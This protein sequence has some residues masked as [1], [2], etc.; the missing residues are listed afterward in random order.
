MDSETM[1]RLPC[2]G[3]N[4]FVLH[5]VSFLEGERARNR[6]KDLKEK[7]SLRRRRMSVGTSGGTMVFLFLLVF[8]CS[9][10]LFLFGY[11]LLVSY[12]YSCAYMNDLL[13]SYVG[14]L[15][16]VLKNREKASTIGERSRRCV[17]SSGLPENRK[18][19]RCC[20]KRCPV[21]NTG[22]MIPRVLP[23]GTKAAPSK[24]SRPRD[25]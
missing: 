16:F 17:G 24:W 9:L 23:Y 2:V 15:F 13:E 10:C 5:R 3:E 12:R 14:C 1:Q 21:W 22:A 11:V 8:C 18:L 19:R 25:D 20:W 7:R 4:C 6:K